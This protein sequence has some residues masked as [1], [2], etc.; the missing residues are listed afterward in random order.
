MQRFERVLVTGAHGFLGRHVVQ[1]LKEGTSCEVIAVGR[2]DHDLLAPGQAEAMLDRY[3]PDAVVHLAAKV[4]GIMANLNRPAE[5]FRENLMINTMVFDACYRAGVRKFLTF[6]GGCSYPTNVPS[7]IA[8]TSMWEGYPAPQSAPYSLA[9][10]MMLVQSRAYRE[11][12]GFDSVVLIPGNVY[13]EHDNF[14]QEYSHVIPAL[15]RRFV[16]AAEQSLPEVTCYGSGR[17]TRD[18]VYARD[19]AALVPWFLE[20]YDSS[21]PVNLSTGTRVSIRELAETVREV[22]GYPG[23]IRWDTAKPDGHLDKIFDVSRLHELGLSCDTP[24]RT[25]LQNTVRWFR[26]AR[27][28]DK[29]RL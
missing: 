21:D 20:N 10:R 19:V 3:H 23:A 18:F 28:Y 27:Q 22:T 24:L 7:P 6:I 5:F 15:I 13:G 9:K 2:R 14:N 25:G 17:P 8:E 16:E 4:G 29:V 12:F 11:Q 26:E 1:A